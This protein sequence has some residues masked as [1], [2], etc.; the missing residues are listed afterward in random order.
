MSVRYSVDELLKDRPEKIKDI[1][2]DDNGEGLFSINI[3]KVT[4]FANKYEIIYGRSYVI[5][6]FYDR[7]RPVASLSAFG[8][9]NGDKPDEAF[10]VGNGE[11]MSETS[12]RVMGYDIKN[13]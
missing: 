1:E 12:Y 7:K 9:C 13:K 8:G 4:V 2:F 6:R 11:I 10:I 3:N 5:I